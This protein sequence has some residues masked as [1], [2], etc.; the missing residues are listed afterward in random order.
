MAWMDCQLP[1]GNE[2]F[3]YYGGYARGHKVERFTER[4]IGCVR[5]KRDR[6]VAREADAEGHLRTRLIILAG[7]SLSVNVEADGGELRA[8]LLDVHGKA[9][10]GFSF[11]DCQPIRGNELSAPLRWKKSLA[12]VNGKPLRLEFSLRHARLYGFEL[13]NIQK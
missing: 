6:Y 11:A 8:Q 13:Q 2:V 7:A 5:M 12:E 9:M 1:V 10:R 3:I 4:Q